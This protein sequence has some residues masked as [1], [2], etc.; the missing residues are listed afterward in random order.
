MIEP[1]LAAFPVLAVVGLGV[2]AL[3]GLLLKP[4]TKGGVAKDDRPATLGQQG[5]YVP[6][7]FGR[8]MV[9]PVVCWVGNRS[10]TQEDSGKGGGK[11]FGGSNAG[12]ETI[13]HES[14]IHALCVG[15]AVQINAIYS[16]GQDILQGI[17]VDSVRTP[18]GSQVS[19]PEGSSFRVYWGGPNDPTD[20][21]VTAALGAATKMPHICRIVWDKKRVGTSAAWANLEYDVAVRPQGFEWPGF[22]SWLDDTLTSGTNPATA[23]W[24]ILTAEYPHGCGIEADSI[25]P[26]SLVAFGQLCETEHL[27][28]NMLVQQGGEAAQAI[29]DI[30]TDTGHM[31]VDCDGM[32][33]IVP[34]RSATPLALT[35]DMVSPPKTAVRRIH[36]SENVSD[37]I[38]WVFSD[39]DRKFRDGV[40]EISNDGSSTLERRTK[41][42]ETEIPT[43][44]HRSIASKIANRRIVEEY[45]PKTPTFIVGLRGLR[46]VRAGHV[47]NL[48]AI[49]PGLGAMRVLSVL[50]SFDDASI[51]IELTDDRY[52]LAPLLAY[53]DPAG[54]P[55][56]SGALLPDARWRPFEVPYKLNPGVATVVVLRSPGG[57]GTAGAHE[58]FSLDGL[59]YTF[60]GDQNAPAIGAVLAEAWAPPAG[61]TVVALGPLLE[62]DPGDAVGD[63]LDLTSDIGGWQ[64]GRQILLVNDEILFVKKIVA[65]GPDWRCVDVIR[66]RFDSRP[67]THSAGRE[68]FLAN[69]DAQKLL[70]NYSFG[71][72]VEIQVKNQPYA[73]NLVVPIGEIDPKTLLLVGKGLRPPAAPWSVAGGMGRDDRK[74]S[75]FEDV[76]FRVAA[77]V[78][79]SGGAGDMGYGTPSMPFDPAGSA[80]ATF[81]VWKLVSG[82]YELMR[83]TSGVA[84]DAT[85]KV[86]SWTYTSGDVSSDGTIGLD[87]YASPPDWYVE[88]YVVVDG[89]TSPSVA[90]FVKLDYIPGDT[91]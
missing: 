80:T 34:I 39:V 48:S 65:E 35:I 4:K 53:V 78:N 52:S 83:T 12:T 13:Y 90:L 63:A 49:A 64:N 51:Q 76:V 88:A 9:G 70:T 45:G 21:T 55:L 26:G 77:A 7:V 18:S 89:M 73:K 40:I 57:S 42:A 91:I 69:R 10:T 47:L 87:G 67:G 1:Q 27:P 79:G 58:F 41:T 14:A 2:L 8:R 43:A 71:Q 46:S 62:V 28:L 16:D 5:D 50:P 60:M 19:L 68:A 22:D 81:L 66:R 38:L 44:I 74:W 20:A 37:R 56:D 86:A 6:L 29:A 30:L 85:T 61:A 72:G 23:V 82:E 32:L 84:F 75:G 3:A 59:E 36:R 54:P 24:Q 25:D 17:K 11:G 31:L 33:A 15:P